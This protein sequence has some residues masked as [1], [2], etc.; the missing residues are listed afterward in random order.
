MESQLLLESLDLKNHE[1]PEGLVLDEPS[2]T[3]G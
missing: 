2:L 1:E 3:V